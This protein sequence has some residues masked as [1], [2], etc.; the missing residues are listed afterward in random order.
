MSNALAIILP[1]LAPT[2]IYMA[3]KRSQGTTPVIAAKDAPWVWLSGAGVVLLAA[4]LAVWALTTGGGTDAV[5]ERAR[6]ENGQ[7]QPSTITDPEP[8]ER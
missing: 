5:Y 2:I 6:F 7:L 8:A 3:F 1:L 4:V